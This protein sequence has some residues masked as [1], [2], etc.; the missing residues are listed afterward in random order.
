M[1]HQER[2]D[3]Y[4]R[5][6]IEHGVNVTEGK[7]VILNCP[8]FAAEFGRRV[9]EYA[10]KAGAADVIMNYLDEKFDRIRYDYADLEQFKSLPEWRAES[11]N[12]YARRG[13]CN[14]FIIAED[15]E[16]FTGVDSEKLKSRAIAAKKAFKEYYDIMDRGE[17]RWT[18][19]A[20][21][22][23][24]WA[25]KIFPDDSTDEAVAKLWKAIFKTVRIDDENDVDRAWREH[26]AVLK[27][28]ARKLNERSF[29]ALHYKNSLGTDFI[30][31]L[32]DEHIW[33][34]GSEADAEG[35]VYFPNMPTEEVF[36]MPDRRRAE[37]RVVAAM[38]LS[39]QGTLIDGFY[40]DFK[41]GKVI[42]HG[43]EKGKEALDRLLDTDEGSRSLGEVALIPH[44]SPISDMGIL[45]YET[46]FDENASCHL[47]L[48][49]C[50]PNT[51]KGGEKLPEE[52]L[53]ARGGNR[54][55]NHVDFMIGTADMMIDGITQTG[56]KIAVFRDGEFVL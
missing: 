53:F 36:T 47:A 17:L 41:D 12:Y 18:I 13:C 8:V 52:E 26:D 48:G 25:K 28:R 21:P 1:T 30:V 55:V 38:P 34:G 44:R 37:G 5:L 50:Y 29:S 27:E 43:A 7:F 56:E 10:Y 19:V 31:G 15:P 23:D 2:L 24:A 45:F 40:L 3:R 4:A 22:N 46:L 42:A 16:I 14:I 51:M 39:Y 54:S 20:Y 9:A 35:V 49:E 32:A 6:T 11:R 33:F